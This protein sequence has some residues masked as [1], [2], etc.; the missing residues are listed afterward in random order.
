MPKAAASVAASI[1]LMIALSLGGVAAQDKDQSRRD[2]IKATA[3]ASTSLASTPWMVGVEQGIFIKHGLNLTLKTV[4][5]GGQL[6]QG[7]TSGDADFIPLAFSLTL[8]AINQKLPVVVVAVAMGDS[9]GKRSDDPLTITARKD[10]GVRA[11]SDLVGKKV[12]LVL[13]G[14]TREYL[15]AVLAARNVNPKNVTL[16]QVPPGGTATA[17]Q[18]ERIDAAVTWE[19]YGTMIINSVPGAYLVQR[20]G[21]F[22]T[23]SSALLTRSDVIQKNPE[24]VRR[25]V[26]AWLEATHW[27]RQHPKEAGEIATR[28]VPGLDAGV[29]AAAIK[30]VPNDPRISGV[31]IKALK[32]YS[33]QMEKRGALPGPLDVEKHIDARFLRQALQSGS[34]NLVDLEQVD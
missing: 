6:T 9:T 11:P 30:H 14:T 5:T 32:D 4:D 19:P 8:S 17:L 13:A 33:A 22:I 24:K 23:Y 34:R 16:V 2:L 20:G 26:A 18:T 29:A 27:T 3:F 12:G 28:W 7:L 31:W 15:D 10:S 1:G 21:R 25:F